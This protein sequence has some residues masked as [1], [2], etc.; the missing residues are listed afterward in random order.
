MGGRATVEKAHQ[1]GP[2]IT[3][4]SSVG[5]CTVVVYALCAG[6]H[7]RLSFWSYAQ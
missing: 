1:E 3:K 5:L 4:L 7:R 6:L 2:M